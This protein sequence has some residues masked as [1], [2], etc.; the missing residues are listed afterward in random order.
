M[1]LY[2]GTDGIRGVF[3]EEITIDLAFKAGYA[4][5]QLGKKVILG[6]DTRLSGQ[7]LA[8]AL[9]MGVIFGGADLFDVGI[10]S[11]PAISFLTKKC[12][13]DFGVMITASHNPE[14]YNG[15][16]IFDKKGFKLDSDAEQKIEKLILKFDKNKINTNK[17]MLGKIF[18]CNEKWRIYR[19]FI[20]KNNKNL[21]NLKVLI[22][23]ANGA[24]AKISPKIFKLLGAKIDYINCKSNGFINNNC[25]A[26][27]PEN[28][29]EKSKNYDICFC[30]DGDGDRVVAIRKG[31]VIDGDRI[32]LILAK[33]LKRLEVNFGGAV[34]ATTMSNLSFEHE[35]LREKIHLFRTDV[36]DKN[37]SKKLEEKNLLIGGEQSGHI[38][39]REYLPTG[40][41]VLAS[42]KLCEVLLEAPEIFDEVLG[43]KFGYQIKE[44]IE[45]KNKSI[46]IKHELSEVLKNIEKKFGGRVLIRP[47]GTEPVLRI[48][49]EGENE[50]EANVIMQL[51]K[52]RVKALD[53]GNIC[54]E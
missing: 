18:I 51:L 32:L 39:L 6:R 52:N 30:Y 2:F 3:G 50:N 42:L 45:I 29:V 28:L 47:S 48:L 24:T 21:K 37:V 25:G 15:I 17:L 53:S 33:Y 43:S 54:A 13:Y 12:G 44:N 27:F 41:G 11:T 4:L 36:G 38:I 46:L 5:S 7:I 10:I 1:S 34:V 20:I 9:S 19:D 14:K 49:V 40:D 8:Y 35:L 26:L 22:D 16:K 31:K 23:C